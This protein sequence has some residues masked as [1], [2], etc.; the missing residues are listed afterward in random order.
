M[1]TPDSSGWRT[2]TH[3]GIVASTS[4]GLDTRNETQR[5]SIASP[6]SKRSRSGTEP[7]ARRSPAISGPSS[8]SMTSCERSSWVRL[9]APGR[10]GSTGAGKAVRNC[11][12]KKWAN[13]P[14]PTSWRRP[15]IRSVS[16][17]SPSD[18]IGSPG[19]MVASAGRRLGYRERAHSPAS[20]MTPRPWVNRECSAVGKTQRALWSWLI[21]R[22]RWTHAVSSRSSSATSSGWRS[23]ARDSSGA[24]RFVSSTYPWIG[25]LMRLTAANGRRRPRLSAAGAVSSP[26][27][28]RR[29]PRSSTRRGYRAGPRPGPGSRTSARAT[30]P[31]A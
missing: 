18:G 1:N 10:R 30:G 12:S 15:A 2:R 6:A 5:G 22:S 13:G 3:A 4:G 19:A 9:L 28:P 17:T 25:S 11:S 14:W 24:R 29:G 7:G 31:S 16:T 27:G 26:T 20:C 23:A 21:R 8:R